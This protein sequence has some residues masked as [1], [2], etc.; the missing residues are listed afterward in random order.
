MLGRNKALNQYAGVA[1]TAEN[2]SPHRLVQMLMEGTLD[3]L[4]AAK[5]QILRK[6]FSGKS[7][8]IS[9]A[10]SIIMTLR[11]S[12][13]MTSGGEVAINLNDLYGYMYNRLIDSNAK[14]D[15]AAIDE[16]V[17]L[18]KEIK[19]AWDAM[20]VE[21]KNAPRQNLAAQQASVAR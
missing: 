13:D 1:T 4:S 18:I 2:A 7:R 3:K 11:N 12:L 17:S 15:I 21:V 14:N 19:S 20:P 5:G 10:M 9:A 8:Q 6:D 16:V